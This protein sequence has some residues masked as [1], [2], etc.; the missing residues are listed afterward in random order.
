M[1]YLDKYK[2]CIGCPVFNYCG[3]VVASTL[4]CAT[5]NIGMTNTQPTH[6][7]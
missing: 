5:D 7:K 6:K 2:N 1:T 4:L 3:T